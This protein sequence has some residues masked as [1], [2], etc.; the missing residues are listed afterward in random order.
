M[1][2]PRLATT[3][4]GALRWR[5]HLPPLTLKPITLEREQQGISEEETKYDAACRYEWSSCIERRCFMGRDS[6]ERGVEGQKF[7][8]M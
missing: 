8:L 6:N 4:C 7:S 2:F 1:M 3:A 5:L